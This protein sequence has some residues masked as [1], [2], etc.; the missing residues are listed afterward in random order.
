MMIRTLAFGAMMV[1]ASA[2]SSAELTVTVSGINPAKGV[3]RVV[4][5]A[6]PGGNARQDQSRNLDAADAKDGVMTTKFLGLSPG[7]YGVVAI[8][9]KS[10]NHALE[11]A[12]T[13][14]VAAPLATSAEVRVTLAEP[15]TAVTVP[16]TSAR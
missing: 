12:M 2:A 5:I 14:S 7:P 15:A 16:L 1:S 6:D 3:V 10:V 11:K 13:G 9:E 8:A 4:V